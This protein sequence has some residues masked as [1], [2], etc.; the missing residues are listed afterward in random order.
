MKFKNLLIDW[1]F[2]KSTYVDLFSDIRTVCATIIMIGGVSRFF[3]FH[4]PSYVII[5]SF[6]G[7]IIANIM[8]NLLK[9]DK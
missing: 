3:G 6:I 8:L 1:I 5:S 9:K 4:N 2:S 7:W